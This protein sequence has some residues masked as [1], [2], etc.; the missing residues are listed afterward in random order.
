MGK[1]HFSK[2]FIMN[3]NAKEYNIKIKR[4]FPYLTKFFMWSMV[5]SLLIL[6][7]GYFLMTPTEYAS[8][9]MATA[10]YM[11]VIPDIIKSILGIAVIGFLVSVLLY[12]YSKLTKKAILIVSEK[13]LFIKG[14]K[15]DFEIPFKKIRKIHFNDLTDIF[16][17]PKFQTEIVINQMN[18]KHTVIRLANYEDSE[19]ALLDLSKIRNVQF[20]F[21][22]KSMIVADDSE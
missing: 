15:I 20:L 22:D 13:S 4:N 5:F 12:H 19:A 21:H 16:R 17:N 8:T 10:Y 7:I 1:Y 9:E 6:C 3:T 18:K 2:C 14:D 11:L